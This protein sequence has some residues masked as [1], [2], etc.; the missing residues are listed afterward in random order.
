MGFPSYFGDQPQSGN[1]KKVETKAKSNLLDEDDEE[2]SS[3]K[4]SNIEGDKDKGSFF[5]IDTKPT[6]K[7]TEEIDFFADNSSPTKA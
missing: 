5:D 7:K 1:F 6:I 3:P 4:K 2:T